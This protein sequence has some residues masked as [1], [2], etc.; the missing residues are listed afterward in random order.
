MAGVDNQRKMIDAFPIVL[1]DGYEDSMRG[2]LRAYND[3]IL[4]NDDA[5]SSYNTSEAAILWWHRIPD[6]RLR[7]SHIH[8]SSCDVVRKQL[9][10]RLFR[11]LFH[12]RPRT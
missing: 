6:H 8:L 3:G 9:Q 1:I 2:E 5:A 11:H 12:L 4:S 10:S 7:E